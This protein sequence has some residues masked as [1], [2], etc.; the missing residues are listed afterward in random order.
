MRKI[1]IGLCAA[2]LLCCT[3]SAPVQPQDDGLQAGGVALKCYK[4]LYIENRP[5]VFLNGRAAA[6]SLSSDLRQQ[7]LTLYR[8]HALKVEREKGGV[9]HIDFSRAEPDTTLHVMQVFLK[10]TYGDTTQEEIVVPMVHA[11]DEWRMK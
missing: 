11:G 2:L 10:V 8:Q 4:A 5:D 1:L 6:E 7:L 3:E 9:R